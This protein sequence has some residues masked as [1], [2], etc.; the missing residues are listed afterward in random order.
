VDISSTFPQVV[1]NSVEKISF[2]QTETGY[3]VDN[4]EISFG[5]RGSSQKLIRKTCGK[6]EIS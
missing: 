4:S 2:A 1:E 3:F 5:S 6:C